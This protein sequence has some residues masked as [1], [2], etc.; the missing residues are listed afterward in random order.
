MQVLDAT[1]SPLA[2]VPEVFEPHVVPADDETNGRA[3]ETPSKQTSADLKKHL[4]WAARE[5]LQA[6][7][8][9]LK[10][11]IHS[12]DSV[13]SATNEKVSTLKTLYVELLQA[14]DDRAVVKVLQNLLDE[15]IA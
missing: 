3:N 12:E 9:F 4:E 11:R 14:E 6:H 13:V 10:H 1:L 5:L 15:R 7:V 2:G 8:N